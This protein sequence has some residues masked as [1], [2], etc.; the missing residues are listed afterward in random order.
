MWSRRLSGRKEKEM[1]RT[2]RTTLVL[3]LA[4]S[5]ALLSVSGCRLEESREAGERAAGGS[6][7]SE[8]P[9]R[10]A[11]VQSGEETDQDEEQAQETVEETEV[12][13]ERVLEDRYYKD[14]DGNEIPDF[15]EVKI[16]RDP[17]VDDCALESDCPG[18]SGGLGGSRLTDEQNTLLILDSSGSM[19]GQDSTGVT[20][21]DAARG[22]LERYVVGTPDSFNLGLMVYG[23]EGSNDRSDREES[24]AGIETFAGLGELNVDNARQTLGQFQPAGW[25][26]IEGSLEAAAEEFAG[27][28]EAANRVVLV[29]DGIE[30]CGGDP[31]AAARQLKESGVAVTVD[32][33]GFDLEDGSDARA[34]R[35]VA[36]ATGGEYADARNA[37]ELNDYFADLVSR[38]VELTGSLACL[39]VKSAGA[40][41]CAAGMSVGAVRELG[42]EDVPKPFENEP[43][44]EERREAI[45]ELNDRIREYSEAYTEQID[46]A[47]GPRIEELQ[48]ELDE[49]QERYE[50]R[51]NEEISFSESC[52]EPQTVFASSKVA[53][54]PRPYAAGFVIFAAGKE[55]SHEG[56]R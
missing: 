29:T 45:Q 51:Y 30:T 6:G 53:P 43:G 39:T 40:K 46:E 18:V 1:K 26:P 14:S 42:M 10:A 24:C 33:V 38:R 2:R 28:E 36:E 37:A 20:K 56:Q 19:A 8:E 21:I 12:S 7:E 16:G 41:A 32:V 52:A 49:V 47:T 44:D 5:V 15:I 54:G 27:K 35:A 11:P 22:A 25:T 4:L 55:I 48:R 13:E 34:L 9:T 17:M 31:V 50:E 3:L 23:H